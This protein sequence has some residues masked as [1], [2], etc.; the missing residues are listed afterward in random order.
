M[1]K[2]SLSVNVETRY[3]QYRAMWVFVLFDLPT[4]TK[5][6]QR[7]AAKFRKDLI[8]FGFCMFQF[9]IYLRHCSSKESS[10]AHMKRVKKILP[11]KGKVVIL[12]VTD[13]QFGDMTIFN[14]K[15]PAALPR[16]EQQLELF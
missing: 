2:D 4:A 3:S 1:Q 14:G 11:P 9:S 10:D 8:S 12:S 7:A 6:D 16:V 13:K 15:E 5:K